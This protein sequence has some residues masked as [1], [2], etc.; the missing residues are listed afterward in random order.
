MRHTT[1]SPEEAEC[2]L[3]SSC[4]AWAH[5]HSAAQRSVGFEEVGRP[6]PSHRGS[7]DPASSGGC[8]CGQRWVG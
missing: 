2:E 8:G 4:L 5:S 1:G 6:L 7:G 3:G